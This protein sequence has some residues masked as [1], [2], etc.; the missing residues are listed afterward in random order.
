MI[1]DG[2]KYYG[3]SIKDGN[4]IYMIGF[5]TDYIEDYVSNENIVNILNYIWENGIDISQLS[6][7][8]IDILKEIRINNLNDIKYN[9]EKVIK[10]TLNNSTLK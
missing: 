8:E 6:N 1:P 10:Y 5:E 2:N 7:K 3:I 9:E 4:L